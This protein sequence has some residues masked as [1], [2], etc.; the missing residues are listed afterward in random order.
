MKI[1]SLFLAIFVSL[2]GMQLF[3]QSIPNAGFENWTNQFYF[4]DPLQFE[5]T[6]QLSFFGNGNA[7]VVK[8]TDATSG[9]FA[10]EL[11][12][13]ETQD[14]IIPGAAFIG[15]A[16]EGTFSGGMP[17]TSRPDAVTGSVKFNIQPFDTAYVAVVFKKFGVPLGY[18]LARFYG[19]QPDYQS[20]S[21]SVNWLFPII[22]PDSMAVL[23]ISSTFF[24]VPMVGSTITMDNIQFVGGSGP[25]PNGDF[26]NWESFSSDEPDLWTSSNLFTLLVSGLSVLKSNDSHSGSWAAQI[27]SKTTIWSDTLGFITNG[28]M[29]DEGPMGGM[30]VENIPNILSGY[31][32]YSPIGSDSALAG[33]WLQRYNQNL[34]ITE[35]LDSAFVLLPAASS[36]TYFEVPVAYNIWPE[37]DTVTIAFGSGNFDSGNFIGLGSTLWID[38]LNITYKPSIVDVNEN[39]DENPVELY[40]NPAHEKLFLAWK[41]IQNQEVN[42]ELINS[43]GQTVISKSYKTGQIQAE[44]NIE[45]LL[46]GIYFY[47]LRYGDQL[48]KGKVIVK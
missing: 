48:A 10:L 31:Y 3:A 30:P 47:Q 46:P 38:D 7:N 24:A 12:T 33:M 25:F 13:I 34:G 4:E 1:K 20:F 21:E 36:Y 35:I 43:N 42:I 5:T 16:G 27:E 40:P 8:T 45:Q 39:T 14:G 41:N 2:A 17:Y 19:N 6:N 11:T 22:S 15:E 29:G 37:P 18:C 28:E 26:E 32:K 9:S 44:L 23:L